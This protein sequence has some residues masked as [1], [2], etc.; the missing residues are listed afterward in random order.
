MLYFRKYK[1]EKK[2][3]IKKDSAWT[4][5]PISFLDVFLLLFLLRVVYMDLIIPSICGKHV[6]HF[7]SGHIF[8]II[9]VWS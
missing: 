8:D 1:I 4:R 6:I 7:K 3:S 2:E 9:W 5:V